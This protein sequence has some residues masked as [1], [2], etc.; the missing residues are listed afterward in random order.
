MGKAA[1]DFFT[2]EQK[3]AIKLAVQQAE[4]ETSGEIRVHIENV[5]E[6]DVLDRAATVFDKLG[7]TQTEQ[8]NGVLFYVALKS[9]KFA[10]LGDLGINAKVPK[11][12]WE[13]TKEKI[14]ENF[15]E[16]LFAEGLVEGITMAGKELKE[17]FP[18][19]TDD[20]NEL[21]DDISFGK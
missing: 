12:F 10:I 2:P 5:C 17:W 9:H 8:R 14:I 11:D 15:K 20:V 4:K 6:G 7:M 18:Y 3:E 19:Q 1:T 13:S 16:G 21:P